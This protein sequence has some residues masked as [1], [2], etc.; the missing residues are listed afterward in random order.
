MCAQATLQKKP[1]PPPIQY[2]LA[3]APNLLCSVRNNKFY[4]FCS[5]TPGSAVI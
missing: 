5:S 4:S 3:A 2:K 1:N